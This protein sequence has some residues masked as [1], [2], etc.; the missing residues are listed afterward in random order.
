MGAATY[1]IIRIIQPFDPTMHHVEALS[2]FGATRRGIIH[3]FR[4]IIDLQHN[5]ESGL[6]PINCG[7]RAPMSQKGLKKGHLRTKTGSNRIQNC[8]QKWT[9]PLGML[10]PVLW[11]HMKQ[12]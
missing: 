11:A 3:Q 12:F 8:V 5:E 7:V 1:L 6:M 9:E 10:M 4:I 2:Q